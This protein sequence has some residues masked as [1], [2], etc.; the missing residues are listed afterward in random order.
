MKNRYLYVFADTSNEEGI[1]SIKAVSSELTEL[2]R[3]IVDY[4]LS[5]DVETGNFE[6]KVIDLEKEEIIYLVDMETNGDGNG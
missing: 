6:I 4:C 5:K 1:D 3:L 2:N